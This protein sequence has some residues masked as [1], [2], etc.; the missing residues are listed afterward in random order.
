MSD[1]TRFAAEQ[2]TENGWTYFTE[3]DETD[4]DRKRSHFLVHQD[5]GRTVEVDF[6]PY[7]RISREGVAALVEMDFP[8]RPG[9][10]PWDGRDLAAAIE[11][12]RATGLCPAPYR[13]PEVHRDRIAAE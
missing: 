9:P 8:A 12:F 2:F 5:T 3:H 1:L 7:E 10:A 11:V 6:T 13:I 4:I